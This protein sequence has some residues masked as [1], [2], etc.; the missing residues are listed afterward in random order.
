MAYTRRKSTKMTAKLRKPRHPL[1]RTTHKIIRKMLKSTA[2]NIKQKENTIKQKEIDKLYKVMS[3]ALYKMMANI[4][5]YRLNPPDDGETVEHLEEK[6]NEFEKTMLRIIE[7][8]P[9]VYKDVVNYISETLDEFFIEE[10]SSSHSNNVMKNVPRAPSA[11]NRSAH[12]N[13]NNANLNN[14]IHRLR[15]L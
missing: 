5:F 12:S 7:R 15:N 1:R 10:S 4:D 14:I 9:Y 6:A 11:P 2:N 8:R 13:A 3:G